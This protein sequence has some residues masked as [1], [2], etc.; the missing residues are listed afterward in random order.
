[1]N[2]TSVLSQYTF[3][4]NNAYQIPHRVSS[5]GLHYAGPLIHGLFPLNR[6]TALH[7]PWLLG[8][9]HRCGTAGMEYWLYSKTWTFSHTQGLNPWALSYPRVNWMILSMSHISILTNAILSIAAA[10]RL[11]RV[12]LFVTL[13]TGA[14]QAAC[15]WDFPGKNSGVGCL[16]LR[17]GIFPTQ[18]A[19]PHFLCLLFPGKALIIFQHKKIISFYLVV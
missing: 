12:W 13:W 16:A 19:N 11:S 14:C 10:Q 1:M 8:W 9:F 17:Q 2:H 6:T 3:K 7:A 4:C 18:G 15:P 5:T